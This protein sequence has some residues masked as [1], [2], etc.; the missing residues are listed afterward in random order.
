MFGSWR[1]ICLRLIRARSSLTCVMSFIRFGKHLVLT[2]RRPNER[3]FSLL[4]SPL[5]L[6]RLFHLHHCPRN[7][8]H[9][10]ASWMPYLSAKLDSF[11]M[12]IAANAMEG[13]QFQTT[14]IALRGGGRSSTRSRGCSFRPRLQCQICSRFGH[15]V[16]KCYYRYHRDDQSSVDVSGCLPRGPHARLGCNGFNPFVQS[17]SGQHAFMDPKPYSNGHDIGANR[18]DIGLQFGDASLGAPYGPMASR[19][20]RPSGL[21][22]SRP[23]NDSI[24]PEP[25]VNCVGVDE[26][27]E[28]VH[29]APWRTKPRARVFS[30]NSSPFDLSQ[31]V[32]LPPTIPELHASDYSSATAYDSNFN[33]T[34]SYIPLPVG[35]TS[36][37]PDSGAT[38][39]VCRNDSALHGFTPYSVFF[40][41][42]CMDDVLKFLEIE[43]P[44]LDD[45]TTPKKLFLHPS[46][47]IPHYT[48]DQIDSNTID[49]LEDPFIR[50]FYNNDP[51]NSQL[52]YGNQTETVCGN[53][54]NNSRPLSLWP[55]DP[56]PYHCSCCRSLRE[57]LHTNGFDVTKLEIHRR[58][59]MICH[60]ILTIEPEHRGREA[61]SDPILHLSKPS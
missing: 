36:W 59:G 38:Y 2:Y 10:N 43:N 46:S 13:P 5:N 39:H 40:H 14:D 12:F 52:A 23:A 42:H 26:S 45:F 11:E 53:D 51:H 19:P 16:Q 22:R 6:M 8:C 25:S 1:T 47:P 60:A 24:M 18:N 9:F 55:T 37:C 20:H 54:V 30:V 28:I 35:S 27:W 15:H 7:P 61:V 48:T 34:N 33:S 41:P 50:D 49:L 4:A 3:Q 57:I 29:E 17:G 58:L 56:I 32:G 44:T 31:F 21:V